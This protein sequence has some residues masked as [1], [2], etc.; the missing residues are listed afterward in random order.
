MSA[1]GP[2]ET[3]RL[4]DA[5]NSAVRREI[6][7]LIWDRELPAGDIA[8]AFMLSAPTISQHLSVLREAG[9]VTMARDGT[10]RRYR[11]RPEAV[12]GLQSLFGPQE[13][14]WVPS[15]ASP[16]SATSRTVAVAIIGT[17]A[18]CDRATAF[19]AFTEAAVYSRWAGVP[20][21]I[22]DGHY[23][24]SMEWGLEV[25]GTYDHVV[26]PSLIV[27]TWDFE[28]ESVPV[29]GAGRRAYLEITEREH[30]CHVEIQQLVSGH[31]QARKMERMWSLMLER[32][33]DHVLEAVDPSTPVAPRPKAPRR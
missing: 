1:T 17:D 30:G 10:F 8:A 11:A 20:V 9:L 3:Q 15:A 29:P 33:R 5:L 21:R 2:D 28:V 14:K 26:E 16:A 4:L 27:M 6:L 19:R 18:P 7:W 32:F 24:A 25:R 31:Q 13:Q 12:A 22:E 23:S